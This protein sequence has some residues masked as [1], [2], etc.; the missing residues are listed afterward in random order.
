MT[1][2]EYKSELMDCLYFGP[3]SECNPEKAIV[4]IRMAE[5]DLS[6]SDLAELYCSYVHICFDS[7]VKYGEGSRDYYEKAMSIFDKLVDLLNHQDTID[8]FNQMSSK[9]EDTIALASQATGWA[10]GYDDHMSEQWWQCKWFE[11]EE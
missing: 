4:L 2:Q 9:V 7:S 5:M 6:P 3:W 1:V 8:L 10:S 11:D